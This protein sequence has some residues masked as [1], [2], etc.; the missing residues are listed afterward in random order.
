MGEEKKCGICKGKYYGFG[1][2]VE[3][4]KNGRCCDKCNDTKVI[5][6]RIKNIQKAKSVWL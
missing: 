5:L 2:N 6:A 4:V 3:P 1:N